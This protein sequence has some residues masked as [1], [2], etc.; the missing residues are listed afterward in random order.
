MAHHAGRRILGGKIGDAGG[1][2]GQQ[3]WDGDPE[4]VYARHQLDSS[5]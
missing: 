3:K 5:V 2:D 4:T 1:Q